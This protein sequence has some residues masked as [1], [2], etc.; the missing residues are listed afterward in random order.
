MDNMIGY[1]FGSLRLS[2][3]GLESVRKTLR[4]QAKLNRKFVI[5]G[6]TMGLYASLVHL[7]IK[8]QNEKIEKME[9]ELKE[10]KSMEEE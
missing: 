1:I 8:A 6:L 9:A 10:L 7:N 4:R 3:E 5:F 2:E